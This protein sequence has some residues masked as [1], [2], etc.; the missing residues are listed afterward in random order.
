M[1]ICIGLLCAQ[2]QA[3]RKKAYAEIVIYDGDL[4][5]SPVQ[6]T[7]GQWG[8][9]LVEEVEETG[10]ALRGKVLRLTLYSLAEGCNL[11]FGKPI[12]VPGKQ[13]SL[14]I[15][16]WVKFV[17]APG[18]RPIEEGVP[19]P[20]ETLPEHGGAAEYQVHGGLKAAAPGTVP[21][22]PVVVSGKANANL[23]MLRLVFDFGNGWSELNYEV[24]FDILSPDLTGWIRLPIPLA[25]ARGLPIEPGMKLRR[26]LI[27]ADKADELFI[28]R[29]LF[30][31]DEEPLNITI[32]SSWRDEYDFDISRNIEEVRHLPKVFIGALGMPVDF[33]V[34]VDEGASI[35]EVLWD[36]DKA[37]GVKWEKPDA[38]GTTVRWFYTKPGTYIVSIIVRD[39][40]GLKEQLLIE[41]KVKVTK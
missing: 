12:E 14:Y 24:P 10:Y 40:L 7:L 39:L 6:L 31:Y 30:V 35:T 15:V 20:Y 41:R 29:M 21:A 25:N 27:G 38:K 37:D 16:M 17:G 4:S 2:E 26:L 22:T 18:E 8:T 3:E 13:S 34:K 32:M 11:I 5:K 9:G 36:F 28:A 23:S 33:S 19:Y 1:A